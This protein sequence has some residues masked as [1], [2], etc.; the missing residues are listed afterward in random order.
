MEHTL[1]HQHIRTKLCTAQFVYAVLVLQATT[2]F[3]HK[4]PCMFHETC[5]YLFT[6]R[7]HVRQSKYTNKL[8][9]RLS[10][11]AVFGLQANTF[12]IRNHVCRINPVRIGLVKEHTLANQIIQTKF[13]IGQ[14]FAQYLVCNQ[15]P[16]FL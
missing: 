9:Y 11:Y 6:K 12:F 1:V 14:I 7:T 8:M 16:C 5:S 13:C 3:F 2:M 4:K 15:I 10:F